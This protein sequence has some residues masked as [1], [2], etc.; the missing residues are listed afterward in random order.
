MPVFLTVKSP[1]GLAALAR[2]RHE[3][4]AITDMQQRNEAV[5][6][7]LQ[8]EGFDGI[9]APK[10]A[11]YGGD[12][13]EVWAAIRPEQIKSATSNNGEFSPDDARITH[14]RADTPVALSGEDAIRRRQADGRLCGV[15][16]FWRSRFRPTPV[17]GC[18]LW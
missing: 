6:K 16:S 17:L 1:G 10:F 2:A 4:A 18:Q 11:G 13:A 3:S 9:N 8:Q 15:R 7:Q 12:G 14:S 5:V